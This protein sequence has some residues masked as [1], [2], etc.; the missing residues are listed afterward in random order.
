VGLVY[1][2]ESSEFRGIYPRRVERVAKEHLTGISREFGVPVI[3]C[4]TW[5]PDG[6]I[7]DGFHLSR[8]GAAEFTALFG[9]EVARTFPEVKP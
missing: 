2:P 6:A 9:P 8:R 1:L 3:D 4:R 5:L 7:V